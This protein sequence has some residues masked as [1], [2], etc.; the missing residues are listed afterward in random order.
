[1]RKVETLIDAAADQ[2][3]NKAR[4]AAA[5][6]VSRGN[7]TDWREGRTHVP[8]K[9]ILQMARIAGWRPLE[10]AVEVYK[11][12]LGELAK[13]LAIGAAA[14]M[15]SFGGNDAAACAGTRL[16]TEPNV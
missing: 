3:G 6:G 5:L 11:E 4:L 8:D 15:L 16:A 13:T 2:A 1:M 12:R 10:T 7:V 14:I 9:H